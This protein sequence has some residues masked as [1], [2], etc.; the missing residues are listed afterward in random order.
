ML[1]F[2]EQGHTL[3]FFILQIYKLIRNFSS[4]FNFLTAF[5]LQLVHLIGFVTLSAKP[6]VTMITLITLFLN[7]IPWQSFEDSQWVQAKILS[8]PNIFDLSHLLFLDILIQVAFE[9]I[10][11]CQFILKEEFIQFALWGT[12]NDFAFSNIPYFS[13]VFVQTLLCFNTLYSSYNHD[14]FLFVNYLIL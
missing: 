14:Y 12:F 2:Q 1:I 5:T 6:Y 9:S 7:L 4:F 11:K 3:S 13:L 10:K 8:M